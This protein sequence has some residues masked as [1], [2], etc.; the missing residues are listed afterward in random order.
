MTQLFQFFQRFG[1]VKAHAAEDETFTLRLQR[2]GI[3][4]NR[5]VSRQ[6]LFIRDLA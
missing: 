6:A 2:S 5:R 1:L 3:Q 4:E